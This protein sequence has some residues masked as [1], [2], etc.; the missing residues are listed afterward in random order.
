MIY[1]FKGLVKKILIIIASKRSPPIRDLT[2]LVIY[3]QVENVCP[4]L[5]EIGDIEI[6]A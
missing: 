5:V 2:E 6:N 1:T 3:P 4:Q